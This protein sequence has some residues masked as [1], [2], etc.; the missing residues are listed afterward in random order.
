MIEEVRKVA[1]RET[2]ES[3]WEVSLGRISRVPD[4]VSELEI[5]ARGRSRR[6]LEHLR[7][8]LTGKLPSLEILISAH[9]NRLSIIEDAT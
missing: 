5:V 4:V 7:V 6:H 8:Q 3:F 1:R 2:A 9:P